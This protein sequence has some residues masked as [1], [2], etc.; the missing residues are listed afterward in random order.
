MSK[1]WGS[2]NARYIKGMVEGSNKRFKRNLMEVENLYPKAD[3][4]WCIGV[5]VHITCQQNGKGTYEYTGF[6]LRDS[7]L[8]GDWQLKEEFI[9]TIRPSTIKDKYIKFCAG[10]VENA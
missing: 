6:D 3:V 4:K 9:R 5:A 7:G 10:V 8:R 2:S 1:F